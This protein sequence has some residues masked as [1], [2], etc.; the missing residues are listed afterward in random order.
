MIC[1]AV[2]FHIQ[3]PPFPYPINIYLRQPISICVYPCS[4]AT[5]SWE[6]GDSSVGKVLDLLQVSRVR[7][8]LHT[9]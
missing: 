1:F 3:F 4:L 9:N 7:V 8:P 6:S 2:Y 5:S